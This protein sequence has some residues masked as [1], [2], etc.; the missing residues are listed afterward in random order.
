M[1]RVDPAAFGAVL[2]ALWAAHD[3][4]DHVI[5][6]TDHQAA[7]KATSWS[8][9]AGHVGLYHA[10]Q[11]ATLGALRGLCGVRPS[12]R[13]TLAGVLLSA[14]THAL[15]D[16]RWPVVRALELTGSAG[17]ARSNRTPTH[18]H[19]PVGFPPDGPDGLHDDR[20]D[21][22][23]PLHGPYLADQALHHTCLAVAAAVIAGG[24][25]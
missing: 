22:P 21:R 7:H 15:L 23:L 17:F 13:R 24:G 14:S 9:M 16:R 2:A 6:Q 11:V 25:R 1:R 19:G 18:G 20:G 5:G 4:A 8:A 10:V 3:L 12:W